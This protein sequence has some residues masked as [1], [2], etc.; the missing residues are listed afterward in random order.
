MPYHAE[1]VHGWCGPTT[2]QMAIEY[3]SGAV[4]TQKTLAAEMATTTTTTT[5]RMSV[6]F[7]SRGHNLVHPVRLTSLDNLKDW[8]SQGYVSI[9]L[10]W[11]DADHA[12]GHYVV[13]TG[14]NETGIIVNDPYPPPPS[15]RPQP[16]SR[17]TGPNAFIPSQ[18][19][20]DLWTNGKQFALMIPYPQ[21]KADMSKSMIK[22]EQPQKITLSLIT[23]PSTW[24]TLTLLAL[25]I[26]P[27]IPLSLTLHRPEAFCDYA[28]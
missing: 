2:V 21:F 27:L 14:Y 28:G 18:L 10:I 8:N 17:R 24:N 20:A 7:I 16:H 22:M 3:I 6:P 19:L 26:H 4:I 13:V 15:P 12:D 23:R 9:I 5:T 25:Q 1:E 11:F